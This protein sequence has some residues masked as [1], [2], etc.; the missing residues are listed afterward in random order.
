MKIV[1]IYGRKMVEIPK[2][3]LEDLNSILMKIELEDYEYGGT[4]S[5]FPDVW[6]HIS[7]SYESY[8]KDDESLEEYVKR[9]CDDIF[10]GYEVGD[11]GSIAD[12]KGDFVVEF[13]ITDNSSMFEECDDIKRVDGIILKAL[14][15]LDLI[16][17]CEKDMGYNPFSEFI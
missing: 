17:Q 1:E 15:N 5:C 2:I 14:V 8:A 9:A 6:N 4:Y 7:F 3:D 10:E 16:E 13:E 12:S 11:K